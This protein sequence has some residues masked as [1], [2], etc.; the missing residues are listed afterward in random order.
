MRSQTSTGATTTWSPCASINTTS[1]N[2]VERSQ[3]I[4]ALLHSRRAGL[5]NRLA[6]RATSRVLSGFPATTARRGRQDRYTDHDRGP[7]APLPE[8]RFDRGVP[9][10]SR[11]HRLVEDRPDVTRRASTLILPGRVP[12]DP[13]QFEI[14]EPPAC[15]FD[16]L[17]E[18]SGVPHQVIESLSGKKRAK[19]KGRVRKKE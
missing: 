7:P 19:N 2:R 17:S 10:R 4:R 13:P 3:E 12:E 15:G 16:D 9:D 14:R 11:G 5:N 1:V 8:S 18:E 6:P